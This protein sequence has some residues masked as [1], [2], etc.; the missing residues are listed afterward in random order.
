MAGIKQGDDGTVLE[1]PIRDKG[2]VVPLN[3]AS[4]TVVFKNGERRFVKDATIKDAAA[5]ICEVTLLAADLLDAG[6]YS[7]QGIVKLGNGNEFASDVE[8]ISVGARL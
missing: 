6:L 8:K 2:V 4:V 3:G 1:L 5:G 7:L